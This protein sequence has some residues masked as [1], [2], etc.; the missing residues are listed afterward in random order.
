MGNQSL[1]VADPVVRADGA[2]ADR[3]A[4]GIVLMVAENFVCRVVLV[5]LGC[6]LTNKYS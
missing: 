1:A 5:V 4:W 6:H 2:G 3:Q